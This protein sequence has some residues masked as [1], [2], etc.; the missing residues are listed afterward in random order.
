[1]LKITPKSFTMTRQL[2]KGVWIAVP[3]YMVLSLF[4]PVLIALALVLGLLHLAEIPV[5]LAVLR[6]KNIPTTE[7]IGKTFLYGFTYWL[8]RSLEA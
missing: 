7:V 6:K 5:A 2:L 3:A 4:M 8:P 1:M